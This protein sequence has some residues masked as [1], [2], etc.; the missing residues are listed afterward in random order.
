MAADPSFWASIAPSVVSAISGLLGVR[1]GGELTER[2]EAAKEASLAKREASYLA[3]LVVA[4]L[5]RYATGCLHVAYDDGT[6][7]GSPAGGDGQFHQTTVTPPTFDPLSLQVDWKVLPVDLMYSV[8][9][10]PYK[11]EQLANHLASAYEYD[12]YPDFTDF[13]WARQHGYAV[14]GLEVSALARK[15]RL[16]AGLPLGNHAQ[17]EWDRDTA[18]RELKESIEAKRTAREARV[19]SLPKSVL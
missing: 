1:L 12:D 10:L 6:S 11:A 3:I 19:A 13:F 17:G 7:E 5:D 15:L 2:R 9:N 16:H 4:H 8:L 14:L 18:L